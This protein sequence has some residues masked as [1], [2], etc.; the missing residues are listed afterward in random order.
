MSGRRF[1]TFLVAFPIELPAEVVVVAPEAATPAPAAAKTRET[2]PIAATDTMVAAAAFCGD[3]THMLVVKL[4]AP[5]EGEGEG[6]G[7]EVGV[8]E[9]VGVG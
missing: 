6:E 8:G 4:E 5:C 3:G 9:P 7:D 1:L 2:A